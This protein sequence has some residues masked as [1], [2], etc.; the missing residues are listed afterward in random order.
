MGSRPSFF[1]TSFMMKCPKCG[2]GELFVEPNPYKLR[3]MH[4]MHAQC[5]ACGISFH[6]EPGF[7]WG[8]MFVSYALISGFIFLNTIWIFFVFGWNIW[9]HIIINSA[10]II[11]LSPLSFR[12]SRSLW[13]NGTMRFIEKKV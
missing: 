1:R 13:L 4:Q 11:L 5:P 12:I 10:F 6:Q 7:Y 9:A 3:T 8:A 2:E